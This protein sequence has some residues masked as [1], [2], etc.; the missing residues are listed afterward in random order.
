[1]HSLYTFDV[2]SSAQEGSWEEKEQMHSE[3]CNEGPV[4]VLSRNHCLGSGK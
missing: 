1:M 4:I 3:L 2:N